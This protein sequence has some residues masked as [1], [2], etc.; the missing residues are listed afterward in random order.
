MFNT[1]TL[2]CSKREFYPE[3]E[4]STQQHQHSALAH[5][6]SHLGLRF[7]HVSETKGYHIRM[8]GK[9]VGCVTTDM[10]NA[11]CSGEMGGVSGRNAEVLKSS[12][13]T[14]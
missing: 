4:N 7:L 14:A 2:R 9:S 3:P 8:P 13:Q 12:S 10:G 11:H 6:S 5:N 1:I